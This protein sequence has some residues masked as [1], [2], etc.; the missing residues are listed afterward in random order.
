[1][2]KLNRIFFIAMIIWMA[3]IFGF[4]MKSGNSSTETS[5]GITDKIIDLF[6]HNYHGYDIERRKYI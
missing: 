4:S 5:N 2:K 1:M 6:L 3:V